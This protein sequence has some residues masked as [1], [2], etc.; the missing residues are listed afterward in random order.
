MSAE[1]D[2]M[3]FVFGC[4]LWFLG[5]GALREC[6]AATYENRWRWSM[7]IGGGFDANTQWEQ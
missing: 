6:A 7:R 2:L 5:G 1:L 4:V 3:P